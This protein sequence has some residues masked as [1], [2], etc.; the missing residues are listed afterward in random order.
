M[1]T[2]PIVALQRPKDISLGE[3][4]SELQRIW[5]QQGGASVT[6]SSTFTMVIYEPEEV[7]QILAALGF[8]QGTIDGIHG[9]LTRAAINQAQVDYDLRLTGRMDP[10]TLARV[11]REYAQLT[12]SQQQYKKD[13][14]SVV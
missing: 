4:E 1:T 13:R 8:Y 2:T 12:P 5:Q 9:P 11:R 14:K 10:P 6:R 7:Q 3:I